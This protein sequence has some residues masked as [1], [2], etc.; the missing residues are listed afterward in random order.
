MKYGEFLEKLGDCQMR[1]PTATRQRSVRCQCE[2]T[3]R[4]TY[5]WPPV[6]AKPDGSSKPC[7]A[8]QNGPC[9]AHAALTK[10][11]LQSPTAVPTE[12]GT[13]QESN[14]WRGTNVNCPVASTYNNSVTGTL[15][16]WTVFVTL[17]C[18]KIRETPICRHPLCRCGYAILTPISLFGPLPAFL[19]VRSVTISLKTEEKWTFFANQCCQTS[20]RALLCGKF[21]NASPVC[22][23]GRS[24]M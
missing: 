4:V 19:T 7:F 9:P 18:H 3:H 20:E 5:E 12:L 10:L 8:D 21:P 1:H 15:Y 23:S 24:S 13:D 16:V 11:R 6:S 17:V 22:P 2:V 14:W